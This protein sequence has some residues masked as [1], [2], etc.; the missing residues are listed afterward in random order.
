MNCLSYFMS[1]QAEPLLSAVALSSYLIAERC[2][3]E[4]VNECLK[5]RYTEPP[6]SPRWRLTWDSSFC[7]KLFHGLG[8]R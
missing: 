8:D 2:T 6:Q 5:S 4:C 3:R 1:K 7:I